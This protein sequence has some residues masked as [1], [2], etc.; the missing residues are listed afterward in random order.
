MSADVIKRTVAEIANC[1]PE[2]YKCIACGYYRACEQ[3]SDSGHKGADNSREQLCPYVLMHGH[4]QSKAEIAFSGEHIL[5]ESRDA[6]C[7]GR[8]KGN[9]AGYYDYGGRG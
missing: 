1:F 2:F 8:D 3:N 7:N 4:R 5:I 6:E 9:D